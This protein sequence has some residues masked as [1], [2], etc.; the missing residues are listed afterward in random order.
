ASARLASPRFFD[1]ESLGTRSP[2]VARPEPWPG[3][4]WGIGDIIEY[5]LLAA[6]GLIETVS[7][8]RGDFVA[9]FVRL[10]R[11]A[12]ERGT[13]EPPYAYIIPPA[14][15]D[16]GA[17]S[18]LVELLELGG[19]EVGR[20]A[21]PFIYER[22]DY[23]A[24]TI[25]I[26]L[27][28]PF[29]GHVKDL[30]DVQHYPEEAGSPYDASGWTLPQQMGVAVIA[31]EAPL[32]VTLTDEASPPFARTLS[33][34]GTGDQLV[35]TNGSALESTLI[36]RALQARLRVSATQRPVIVDGVTLPAGSVVISGS[37][38]LLAELESHAA[39][40][41]VQVHRTR[42]APT[43]RATSGLPRIGLYHPWTA[44]MDEGWTR[45]VLET[46]QIPHERIHNDRIR[47]G[48]LDDLDVILF[49]HQSSESILQGRNPD[50]I[51]IEF[52]GGVGA[53]GVAA[54]QEWVIG[55]GTIIALGKATGFILEHFEIPVSDL[56][57]VS[58]EDES[59]RF[60]APG[61]I[62]GVS[63]TQGTVLTSGV[64]DSMSVYLR[65]GTGFAVEAPAVSIAEYWDQPLRSGLVRNPEVVAGRSALVEAP[66][67]SGRAILFGF[68]PQH[69]GQTNGTFKLL[70][71]ALL[72]S[73]LD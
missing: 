65:E 54:L 69:R 8:N 31:V 7:S 34:R 16:P 5:E 40:G 52:S 13:N 41:G 62:F 20:A 42:N 38:N 32:G 35:L 58:D 68:R 43:G 6:R 46:H 44:S 14:Q 45:W 11:R 17:V 47:S 1:P 26:S 2:T 25:V 55:G 66:L 33:T 39:A 15:R 10:G 4:W 28:Q 64:P 27:A 61:S 49:T 70:F 22:V 51:P 63:V 19:V 73:G 71:N 60:S 3:G 36:A 24:G 37:G 57:H 21:E 53:D 9:R 50:E 23:P 29:R 59:S 12:V 56:T 48:N 67:G 30:F 18:Q 72:L